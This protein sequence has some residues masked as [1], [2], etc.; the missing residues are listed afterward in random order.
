M[1][2][3]FHLLGPEAIPVA[4][5]HAEN[6]TFDFSNRDDIA[7]SCDKSVAHNRHGLD[8][9]LNDGRR[10]GIVKK[11]LKTEKGRAKICRLEI[12]KTILE[13]VTKFESQLNLPLN[14]REVVKNKNLKYCQLKSECKSDI[15]DKQN[16]IVKNFFPKSE[17]RIFRRKKL[18]NFSITE[19]AK[20]NKNEKQKVLLLSGTIGDAKNE[21][22]NDFV[23][24]LRR[25]GFDVRKVPVLK[26]TFTNQV[27]DHS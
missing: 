26:T 4:I 21:D 5:Y 16:E 25:S 17:A 13:F 11:F 24:T 20:A 10:Q 8:D 12:A 3:F 7:L 27:R 1:C 14:L 9:V 6:A 22:K 15:S 18:D 19:T 2:H 23:E